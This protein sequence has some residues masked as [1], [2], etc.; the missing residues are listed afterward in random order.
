MDQQKLA[1]IYS[2]K[3]NALQFKKVAPIKYS[4]IKPKHSKKVIKKQQIF[5]HY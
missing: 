5:Y 4:I 1:Q 2:D 3:P